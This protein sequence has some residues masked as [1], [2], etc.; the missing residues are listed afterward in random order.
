M[1]EVQDSYSLQD[2]VTRINGGD[3]IPHGETR[4]DEEAYDRMLAVE[5]L[6]YWLI[7]GFR[8]TYEY[9]N[10]AEYSYQKAGKE[11]ERYLSGLRDTIDEMVE[12]QESEEKQDEYKI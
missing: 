9:K 3:F 2:I 4:Y 8:Y 6:I 11:A 7:D 12:P 10:R 5:N 1:N